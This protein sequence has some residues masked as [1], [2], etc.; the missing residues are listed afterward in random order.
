MRVCSGSIAKKCKPSVQ[1]NAVIV[2]GY[3]S[4]VT[5]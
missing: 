1:I 2:F 4:K 3:T 5:L